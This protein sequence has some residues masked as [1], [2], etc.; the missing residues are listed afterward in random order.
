MQ[1]LRRGEKKI[2]KESQALEAQITWMHQ[3]CN[4]GMG[5]GAGALVHLQLKIESWKLTWVERILERVGERAVKVE[6]ETQ[7]HER[8]TRA[9]EEA[10]KN[11]TQVEATVEVEVFRLT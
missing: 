1:I 9:V 6:R 3:T 8:D 2:E 4:Q 5:E 7:D 10:K 11:V